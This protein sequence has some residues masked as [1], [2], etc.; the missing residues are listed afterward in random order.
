ELQEGQIWESLQPVANE[1]LAEITVIVDH[2][3]LQ[4]DAAL[5]AVSDLGRLEDKLEAFGWEVR[6]ADGHDLRA[7]R[8]VFAHFASVTDR[9]KVLI[10]DTVKGKG[11]SFM[12]GLACGDQT[13]HFH[14]GAPS[15]KDYIAAVNEIVERVNARL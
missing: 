12:E 13:Y 7:V 2:N 14:A 5:S 6:R 3:K 1:R 11:V 9:P 4:S 8:D 15:L 10:A